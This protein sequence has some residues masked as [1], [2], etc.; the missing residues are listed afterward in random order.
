LQAAIGIWNSE[1]AAGCSAVVFLALR[2]SSDSKP[3][4]FVSGS[5]LL[6]YLHHL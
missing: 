4:D 1:S 5:V 3:D 6:L 2:D